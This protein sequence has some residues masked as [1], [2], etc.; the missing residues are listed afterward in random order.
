MSFHKRYATDQRAEEEGVWVDF[1]AGLKV[2]LRRP[3]SV[4]TQAKKTELNR[5]FEALVKNGG[6]LSDADDQ[7][8]M[9]ELF[10]HSIV[11]DWEGV[12]VPDETDPSKEVSV[13]ATPEG[14]LSVLSNPVYKDFRAD[15]VGAAL[16]RDTFRAVVRKED[17][18]N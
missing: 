1:G 13:P 16:E 4:H 10:A 15:I 6:K 2:K 5:P 8:L 7:R 12:T 18:K 9:N 3:S 11:V 17:A 14:I